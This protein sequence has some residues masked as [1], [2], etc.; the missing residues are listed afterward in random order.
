MP[1]TSA[2]SPISIDAI[3]DD[4]LIRTLFQPVVHLDSRSVTG[5][6]ALTRG[7]VGSALESPMALLQAARSAGRLGELDWLCRAQ[8]MQTAADSGLPEALSWLVNVEPAGLAMPCPDHLVPTMARARA[9]LRV[10]LEVVERDIHGNVLELIQA[11]D[12]ARR[13]SWGVALDD[14]GAEEASLALLP[15]LRPDV[16]K[17]DMSLVRQLPSADASAVTAG[18]R[19]YAERTGAVILAE[20]IETIDHE[21]LA[22]VFGATY[23]QGYF[24]GRPQPLPVTVA[25]PEHPIPL[26]QHLAAVDGRTP[27]EVL[28]ATMTPHREEREHLRHITDHLEAEAGVG[29]RSS[30][31]L[32]GLQSDRFFDASTEAR[33]QALSASNALTIVLAEGLPRHNE[34][35]YHVG[36]LSSASRLGREWVLI[37][38]NLH[39]SAAFVARD[40]GDTGPDGQRRFDFIYTHDRT[41]VVSAARS[42]IQ[43]LGP[44][45]NA[46]GH[47]ATDAVGASTRARP[48]PGADPAAIRPPEAFGFQTSCHLVLDFLNR[49]MPMAMWTITRVENERQTYLYL[50]D[51]AYGLTVGGAHPWRDSLCVHMADGTGPRIA[52]DTA[53]VPVYFI[54]SSKLPLE[55]KAYAGAPIAEPDGSLF[56]AICGL[57]RVTR[58]DLISFGPTLDVLSQLLTVALAGDRALEEAV[59]AGRAALSTA[60]TDVPTGLPNRRAWES[61]LSDLETE[62]STYGDPTVIVVIDVDNPYGSEQSGGYSAEHV[63]LLRTAADVIRRQIPCDDFLARLGGERFAILLSG[64]DA[65]SAPAV[66]RNLNRALERAAIT[67]T[68]G[69]APLRPGATVR[70]AMERANQ[71]CDADRLT[72]LCERNVS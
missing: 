64:C 32:A 71:A 50:D 67:A 27:F 12:Q 3:I 20:G 72:S 11:T 17:L 55:L 47:R 1:P 61:R 28:A 66:V 60:T 30:V 40:C 19:A 34:A 25:A 53:R 23:G 29:S 65:R 43:E 62:F 15:F 69:W 56:G 37:V 68:I 24:Y 42:F 59:R 8:A 63:V 22:K 51:N 16:V 58:E 54:A 26:R 48:T 39:Y 6:E 21:R 57:D 41:S 44:A 13:D 36:P 7:P 38:L 4:R 14:V 18:V 70:H 46:V 5:F 45:G 35:A 31:L 52:P 10:I 9:D 2:A 33:Y 49:A